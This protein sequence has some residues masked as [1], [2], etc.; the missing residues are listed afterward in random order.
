MLVP[1]L[2][3]AFVMFLGNLSDAGM[4]DPMIRRP[5]VMAMVVGL[6]LGDLRKGVLMGASLEVI[7]LGINGIGGAMPADVMTGSIFGTAFAI[8]N[9]QSTSVA[10]SLAIPIGLLAVFI[11][12]IVMFIKGLMVPL[13][14]RFAEEDNIKKIEHL[15]IASIF[16]GPLIYALIGFLGIYLGNSSI[17]LLVH[18]IPKFVMDGLTVLSK[19]LPA[20]GIAMLLNMIQEKGNTM[21]MILGLLMASYLKLPLIAIAILGTILAIIIATTDKQIL[22]NKNFLNDLKLLG[23]NNSVVKSSDTIEEDFFND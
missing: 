5:L 4:S 17:S 3:V 9:H 20:L 7:F 12:Q 22:D 15:Q 2:C 21:Y 16:I 23:N 13:F 11:K 1:A 14:N 8:L 10:L 6:L 19:V 18:S